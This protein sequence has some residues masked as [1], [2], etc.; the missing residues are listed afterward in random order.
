MF[1]HAFETMF[2]KDNPGVKEGKRINISA[3]PEKL[4]ESELFGHE[5]GAFT[6]A[7]K[8]KTGLLESEKLVMLEEIGELSKTV[9]A[10]LLTFM[11]DGIYYSVGNVKPKY[12]KDIQIIATTNVDIKS[13][14]LRQ[15]FLDR[16]YTFHISALHARRGDILY[17]LAYQY[18]DL[19]R[20]LTPGQIMLILCYHWPGNM[21][22]IEK[23]GATRGTSYCQNDFFN[24]TTQYYKILDQ[25][26]E[27]NIN[28]D[29][30]EKIFKKANLSIHAP[31]IALYDSESTF[32]DSTHAFG[33]SDSTV[34]ETHLSLYD[35]VMALSVGQEAAFKNLRSLVLKSTDI[36][37]NIGI[38]DEVKDFTKAMYCFTYLPFLFTISQRSNLNLFDIDAIIDA[39][40]VQSF[41]SGSHSFK[42]M[43]F[44]KIEKAL[45]TK[46]Y[47]KAFDYWENK[48]SIESI[49]GTPTPLDFFAMT[50]K[51]ILKS[52]YQ[53]LLS[54]I[55]RITEV[56]RLA[57]VKP[58]TLRS[59]LDKL[60]V[61]Y[62]KL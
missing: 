54:R 32:H 27:M 45:I 39:K 16:C 9:Q 33:D 10:K 6:G 59:K 3:I 29:D 30:L 61:Q 42:N 58:N 43:S 11:E 49:P 19:F 51:D 14:K 4:I 40:E 25:L 15:D 37:Q 47:N 26:G 20:S 5:K 8:K 36:S 60:G 41:P 48:Y 13:D 28:P 62:K 31:H 55:K 21:R 22:E 12:A 1:T 57:G 34:E 38:F 50:E 18:P 44:S 2:I 52:Y 53:N 46:C 56:A 17:I 24:A 7:N 35:A 23:F